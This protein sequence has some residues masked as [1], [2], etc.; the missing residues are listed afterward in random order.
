MESKLTELFELLCE[1]FKRILKA[2]DMNTADRKVLMEFL[3]DND[4]SCVGSKNSSIQSI[5]TNLPFSEDVE[6]GRSINH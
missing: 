2:E 3:K 5:V 6:E 1:D 4:I